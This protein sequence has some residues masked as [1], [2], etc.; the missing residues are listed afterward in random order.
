MPGNLDSL[1]TLRPMVRSAAIHLRCRVWFVGCLS[2]NS[3][4]EVPRRRDAGNATDPQTAVGNA[5]AV[6]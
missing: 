3:L 5:N 1:P 2:N 6:P 4:S